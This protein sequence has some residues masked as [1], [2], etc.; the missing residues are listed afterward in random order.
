MSLRVLSCLLAMA[1]I[2]P[3][4]GAFAAPKN[5]QFKGSI[6]FVSE[7]PMEKI[8]GNAAAAGTLAIDL[9]DL[10]TIKGTFTVPVKSMKT[11]NDTRDEHL[12]SDK[13]LNE[14]AHPTIQFAINAAK[15]VTPPKSAGPITT[16]EV[17][18]TGDFTLHAVTKPMT[19]QVTVKWKENKLKLIS[20]FQIA[21]ADYQVAGAKGIVG[22]KV[23]KSIAIKVNL[24][25]KTE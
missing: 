14:P 22:S 6:E 20:S 10:S 19:A 11:G 12:R 16:A 17:A 8:V 9:A 1:F 2:T 23:G 25:G 7:A 24:V 21:L 15:I 3:L 5:A 18:L 4:N 13:W